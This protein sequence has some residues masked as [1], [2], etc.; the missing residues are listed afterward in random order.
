MP[1]ATYACR[2]C[3]A[4]HPKSTESGVTAPP[5][6]LCQCG[7]GRP[8]LACPAAET[9]VPAT[10]D[11]LRVGDQVIDPGTEAGWTIRSIRPAKYGQAREIRTMGPMFTLMPFDTLVTL[12]DRH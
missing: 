9:W 11:M 12:M 7:T 1:A 2:H 5:L 6:V 4:R 10:P 8:H 3:A